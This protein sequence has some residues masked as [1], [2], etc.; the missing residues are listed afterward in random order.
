[1]HSL[2]F[3]CNHVYII[4]IYVIFT[5]CIKFTI[6]FFKTTSMQKFHDWVK[7]RM[8]SLFVIMIGI[9]KYVKSA[10]L[11]DLYIYE[12]INILHFITKYLRIIFPKCCQEEIFLNY[13]IY[14]TTILDDVI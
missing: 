8:L 10:F 9:R 12:K 2:F 5:L 11:K 14:L 4:L 13:D 1:M 6:F 7:A 3:V